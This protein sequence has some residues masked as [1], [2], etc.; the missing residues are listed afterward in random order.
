MAIPAR[1]L[2]NN[3]LAA[4]CLGNLGVVSFRDA[5]LKCLLG[6]HFSRDVKGCV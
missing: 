4:E 6:T 5:V 2:R 3:G 1:S